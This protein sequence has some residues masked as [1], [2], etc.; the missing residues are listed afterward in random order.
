MPSGRVA[1]WYVTVTG[2]S[3]RGVFAG[4]LHGGV[5]PPI[6]M[7]G[8]DG[9]APACANAPGMIPGATS[10]NRAAYIKNVSPVVTGMYPFPSDAGPTEE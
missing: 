3:P 9:S 6:V 5:K 10:P 1:P 8:L 4:A 7:S 2:L